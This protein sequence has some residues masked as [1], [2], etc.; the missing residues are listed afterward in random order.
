M[1]DELSDSLEKFEEFK[2]LQRVAVWKSLKICK[3]LMAKVLLNSLPPLILEK[4]DMKLP[5]EILAFKLLRKAS[6]S[7]E[8]KNACSHRNE[9]CK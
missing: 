2:D 5:S 4:L 8:E 7:K 1:K 9:L 6:I 3:E